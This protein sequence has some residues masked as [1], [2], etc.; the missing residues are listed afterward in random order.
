VTTVRAPSICCGDVD[1][2]HE[3]I[4]VVLPDDATHPYY[5]FVCP[6]CGLLNDKAADRKVVAILQRA[7]CRILDV[8]EAVSH[9]NDVE[10]ENFIEGGLSDA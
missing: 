6:A 1:L 2:P 7:G 10:L 5:T 9:I 8:R 4:D 3:A